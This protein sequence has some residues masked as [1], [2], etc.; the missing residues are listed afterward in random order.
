MQQK[1][2]GLLLF[3]FTVPTIAVHLQNVNDKFHKV[4]KRHYSGE[5]ENI[6][7]A[8]GKFCQDNTYRI[9]LESAGFCLRYDKNILLCFFRFTVYILLIFILYLMLYDF[10]I[11]ILLMPCYVPFHIYSY[12]YMTVYNPSRHV[13]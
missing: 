13:C 10:H 2:F 12:T 9:L 6:C 7:I 1:H 5:V 8:Y 3:Q 4:V 11:R